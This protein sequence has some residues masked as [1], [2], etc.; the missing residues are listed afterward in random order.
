MDKEGPS[1]LIDGGLFLILPES[2]SLF[3]LIWFVMMKKCLLT[4][5]VSFFVAFTSIAQMSS[6]SGKKKT[7]VGK[8]SKKTKKTSSKKT[9]EKFSGYSSKKAQGVGGGGGT[10][11]GSNRSYPGIG[12]SKAT[13]ALK[14]GTKYSYPGIHNVRWDVDKAKKAK[15]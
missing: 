10:G 8:N 6:S 9:S 12:K 7:S 3:G 5:L 14:G 15:K 2:L 11:G 13:A 4:I 1:V